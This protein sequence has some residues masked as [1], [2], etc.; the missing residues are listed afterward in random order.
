MTLQQIGICT[1]CT[2]QTSLHGTWMNAIVDVT[3]GQLHL[4][5]LNTPS[6]CVH[7]STWFCTVCNDINCDCAG[8]CLCK[9]C[10]RQT[11]ICQLGQGWQKHCSS[12]AWPCKRAKPNVKSG[13]STAHA[14]AHKGQGKAWDRASTRHGKE[15]GWRLVRWQRTAPLQIRRVSSPCRTVPAPTSHYITPH[16]I[17]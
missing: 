6:D 2:R 13:T 16:Y 17:H 12:K 4:L 10:T 14:G 7:C 11:S 3:N 9:I 15:A 1:H 8:G 5:K